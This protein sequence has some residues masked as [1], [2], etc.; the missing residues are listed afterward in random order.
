[1]KNQ[2]TLT[3]ITLTLFSLSALAADLTDADGDG[4]PD[5]WESHWGLS[6]NAFSGA[7]GTSGRDGDPDNDGLS[8]WAEYQAGYID[9]GSGNV[10]SNY[11]W[12]VSG[13]SP[14]NADSSASGWGDFWIRAAT[15]H[16]VR[17]G[18]MFSDN[19]KVPSSYEAKTAW[20]SSL[21]YDSDATDGWSPWTFLDRWRM[22][23]AGVA[24]PSVTFTFSRPPRDPQSIYSVYAYSSMS[25]PPDAVFSVPA[26]NRTVS[27]IPVSGRVG[28]DTRYWIAHA[29]ASWSA[30]DPLWTAQAPS[31]WS[32]TSVPIDPYGGA[33]AFPVPAGAERVQVRRT[34]VDGDANQ[35]KTLFDIPDVS[36][37]AWICPLDSWDQSGLIDLDWG[38]VDAP[39]ILVAAATQAVYAVYADGALA[40]VFT[41]SLASTRPACYPSS[42]INGA[43]VYTPRPTFRWQSSS[44]CQVWRVE[45]KTGSSVGQ[46]VYYSK[47]TRDLA[48]ESDGSYAWT[49]PIY[50]GSRMPDGMVFSPET[51][52][53]WRVIAM[54]PKF[55]DTASGWSG[56]K[57]FR[58]SSNP[59]HGGVLPCIV[60][61]FG[62]ATELLSSRVKVQAFDN[63]GFCGT[64]STEYTLA[65][66]DLTN[67]SSTSHVVNASLRV[68]LAKGIYWIRALIDHNLSA[69]LDAWE[70][71]GASFTPSFYG[72][73]T[74]IMI[75]DADSD[76]DWFPD[77][78]E[79]EQNPND[80]SF[81]LT[82]PSTGASSAAE[83][84]PFL[85]TDGE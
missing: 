60:R 82:G 63:P 83:I 75:Y 64:P 26:T 10:Y 56:W 32:G 80:D 43:Y 52:Y 12:A 16:L 11:A 73:T 68:P 51:V 74:S 30:G 5:L 18:W 24:A 34:S 61:Y 46:T 29:G 35:L 85:S 53:V 49:L 84:N 37:R 47:L 20:S 40:Y 71:W 17:L 4:L 3:L 50:A 38:F 2:T 22:D 42:P 81:A 39:A 9:L 33:F 6:T 25:G 79:F 76:R 78:W 1:M 31:A 23:A 41:N 54:T 8:N 13:L 7:A 36:G 48:C 58:L 21:I 57:T 65:G 45:I 69:T 62:A 55:S 28:P 44:P 72:Q 59:S 19:D 14:T 77:A 27:A 15:N 70:S 67:L 66:A